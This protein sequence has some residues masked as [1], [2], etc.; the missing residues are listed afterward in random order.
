ML[1]LQ[2]H[3]LCL[4]L[5]DLQLCVLL[6]LAQREQQG[7]LAVNLGLEP[8]LLLTQ[9]LE[10]CSLLLQLLLLLLQQLC[11]L[12][13]LLLKHRNLDAELGE[14][15]L[16]LL[17]LRVELPEHGRHCLHLGLQVPQL[18][19]LGLQVRLSLD[20]LLLQGRLVHLQGLHLLGDLVQLL[21]ARTGSRRRGRC[22][23]RQHVQAKR[24]VR[25]QGRGGSLRLGPQRRGHHVGGQGQGHGRAPHPL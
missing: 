22:R 11:L 10:F 25:V 14:S 4:Y 1:L 23:R 18:A 21:V 9:A 7:L 16:G 24:D 17:L 13:Q 3:L 19:V 2:C 5:A 15:L 6:R 8:T 12:L 20:D